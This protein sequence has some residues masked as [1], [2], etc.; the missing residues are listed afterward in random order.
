MRVFLINFFIFC[1]LPFIFCG[2]L[3]ATYTPNV[4]T[5]ISDTQETV[6]P[7]PTTCPDPDDITTCASAVQEVVSGGIT[8]NNTIANMGVQN[9]RTGG[10]ANGTLKTACPA[11]SV[12]TWREPR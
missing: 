5:D 7:D 3:F 9:V 10:V 2:P 8:K 6:G 4:N 1:A 12:V 11:L